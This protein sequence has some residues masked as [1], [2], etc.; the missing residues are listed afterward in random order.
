[1]NYEKCDSCGKM[2]PKGSKELYFDTDTGRLLCK[3][4]LNNMQDNMKK[5]YE[6]PTPKEVKDFLDR[7][8]IG[9]EKA[10]RILSVAV[11]AASSLICCLSFVAASSAS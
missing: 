4:C 8:V 5:Q 2:F 10:K 11:H 6:I 9:Q 1:M 7:R 3:E